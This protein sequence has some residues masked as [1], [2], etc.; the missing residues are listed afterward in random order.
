MISKIIRSFF[1]N[2]KDRKIKDLES[3]IEKCEEKIEK[4]TKSID[5]LIK[6]GEEASSNINVLASHVLVMRASMG[7]FHIIE[8][9]P[10]KGSADDDDLIN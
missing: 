5:I 1:E 10:R 2:E 7:D 8:Q 9:L 6:F 4:L 3:K